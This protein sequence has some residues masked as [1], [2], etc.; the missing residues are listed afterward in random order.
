MNAIWE[1]IQKF[2]EVIH[3]ELAVDFPLLCS[4][5]HVYHSTFQN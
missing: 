4:V 2:L 3:R 5:A 1:I